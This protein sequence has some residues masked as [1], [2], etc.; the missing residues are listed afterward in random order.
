MKVSNLFSRISPASLSTFLKREDGMQLI[1]GLFVFVLML[2]MGGIAIDL[3]R[4]ENERVRMQS[5]ADRAALAAA[6]LRVDNPHN[7]RSPEDIAM[8]WFEAEGLQ[9]FAAGGIRVTEDPDAG[10]SVLVAPAA[11]VGSMFMSMLG[12][13]E[14]PL[15]A[16]AQALEA[17]TGTVPDLEL[18]M[19][20]DVSG[21]MGGSR[22]VNLRNAARA[23]VQD[24]LGS[25]TTGR[26]ALTL[27]PYDG[28]VLPDANFM[29]HFTQVVGN[30]NWACVD[31]PGAGNGGGNN[32]TWRDVTIGFH[33]PMVR[34]S[35]N[36]APWARIRVMVTEAEAV[37][38]I[39]G[40][41]ARGTT[42]IDLGVRWAAMYFNPAIRPAIDAEIAAGR[43][44]PAH[45]GRP[46]DWNDTGTLKALLLMTDGMNCCG[47]RGNTAQMDTR[48]HQTCLGLR[49][50]GVQIY[51]VAFEAP[52]QGVDLMRQCA[53]SDGHFFNTAGA[54]I[55]DVFRSIGTHL[56][57]QSLRLTQ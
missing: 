20:L 9:A 22:I 27:V 14:L 19:V 57:T 37:T 31:F 48:T 32:N 1:L 25:D 39:N 47:A 28:D 12:V 46:A 34:R 10:R 38:H 5:T 42:S 6:S 17:A 7:T 26:I 21:S 53:S 33:L 16:P 23:L 50:H 8:A 13:D 2:L 41:V 35:C 40:L 30:P 24:L 55:T 54:G 45:A 44:S 56:Q 11:Q 15:V 3:M 49:D 51:A 52:T 36:A 18:V 43:I 29:S 4:Y